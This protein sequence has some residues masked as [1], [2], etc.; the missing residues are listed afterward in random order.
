MADGARSGKILADDKTVEDCKIKEKDFLVVMVSKVSS[1]VM[2]LFLMGADP[3]RPAQG[4]ARS[5]C[6]DICCC[7][8]TFY[9]CCSYPG[10]SRCTACCTF[11]FHDTHFCA[12][13]CH[14]CSYRCCAD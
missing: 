5:F 7:S 14:C 6:F 4:Y 1:F 2:L 13:C 8:H 9:F 12:C 10:C 3:G 11:A